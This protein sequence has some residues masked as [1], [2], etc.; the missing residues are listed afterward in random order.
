MKRLLTTM[1][2][3]MTVIMVSAQGKW[4]T[5]VTEGDDLK[6]TTA[7][8]TYVYNVEGMGR[9]GLWDWKTYQFCL[10]SDEAQFNID[11]GYSRYTGSYAGVDIVVGIYDDNDKLVEKFKMWLDRVDNKGN[12]MVKTRNQ[13]AMSNPVGQKGKV[14]KIFNV[15]NGGKGYVRIVTERFQTTDFDIKIYPFKE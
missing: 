6:G 5:T 15:L 12:Q 10:V 11:A 14:K 3:L 2:M 7:G 4:E 8:K 9:F 13:G 1:M